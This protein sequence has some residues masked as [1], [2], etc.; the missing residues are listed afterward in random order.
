[1]GILCLVLLLGMFT[2]TARQLPGIHKSFWITMLAVWSVGICTLNWE[3][4]QPAWLL[5]GLLAAHGG[6]LERRS[7]VNE[8]ASQRE[9][10]YVRQ[11]V[12]VLS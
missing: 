6:C 7:R 5:L 11:P 8:P 4:S 9:G 2:R 1:M 10:C 12:E 3:S